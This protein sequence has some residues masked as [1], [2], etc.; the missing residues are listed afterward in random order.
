MIKISKCRISYLLGTD[1]DTDTGTD[2]IW[3]WNLRF[4]T[5]TRFWMQNLY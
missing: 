3:G 2:F 5:F 1:T 4:L